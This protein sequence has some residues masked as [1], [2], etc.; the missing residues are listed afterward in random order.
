MSPITQTVQGQSLT[1]LLTM[2][3]LN[4]VLTTDELNRAFMPQAHAAQAPITSHP[5]TASGGWT[6]PTQTMWAAMLAAGGNGAASQIPPEQIRSIMREA[7]IGGGMASA[8]AIDTA[9]HI[10][11]GQLNR[12]VDFLAAQIVNAAVAAG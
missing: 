6:I 11:R 2:A 3:S 7:L 8:A 4:A 10:Q 5:G 1:F 12:A 9:E